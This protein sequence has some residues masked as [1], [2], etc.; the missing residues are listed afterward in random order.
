MRTS[1]FIMWMMNFKIKV[2]FN[3]RTKKE[4]LIVLLFLIQ[5]NISLISNSTRAFFKNWVTFWLWYVFITVCRLSLTA[6]SQ[7]YLLV[8]MCRFLTVAF[9]CC[10]ARA[11]RRTG[12]SSCGLW[13]PEHDS[14]V[15]AHKLSCSENEGTRD[16]TSVPCIAR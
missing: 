11:L 8:S 10:G 13:A 4:K 6:V 3:V 2:N 14:V 12:L 9:S 16:W 1:C 15:V 5:F 7:G